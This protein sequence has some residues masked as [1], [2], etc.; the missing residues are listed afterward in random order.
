MY[1]HIHV[2]FDAVK[3]FYFN[4]TFCNG[5]AI[6]ISLVYNYQKQTTSK[7]GTKK[8]KLDLILLCK[9]NSQKPSWLYTHKNHRHKGKRKASYKFVQYTTLICYHVYMYS[10]ISL[11]PGVPEC[12]V[13]SSFQSSSWLLR[14]SPPQVAIAIQAMSHQCLCHKLQCLHL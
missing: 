2:A 6:I 8:D 12:T 7:S 13:G 5:S 4:R 9:C 11:P 14:E 10:A 1:I 3:S